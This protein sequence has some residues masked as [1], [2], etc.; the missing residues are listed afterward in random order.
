M[1]KKTKYPEKKTPELN[2]KK[3]EGSAPT[4]NP[5][6]PFPGPTFGSIEPLTLSTLWRLGIIPDS[7]PNNKGEST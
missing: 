2:S 1:L 6:V 4:E 7:N 3:A 5:Y